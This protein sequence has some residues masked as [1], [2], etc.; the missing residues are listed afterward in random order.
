MGVACDVEQQR[1]NHV[2]ENRLPH[3]CDICACCFGLVRFC[4]GC[5]SR[6]QP[7]RAASARHFL[8][9]ARV[10]SEQFASIYGAREPFTAA[11]KRAFQTP[12]GAEVDRW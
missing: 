12:T 1:Q 10:S 7:S 3:D 5:Q 6:P 4:R 9:C 11:E 8:Q 2:K